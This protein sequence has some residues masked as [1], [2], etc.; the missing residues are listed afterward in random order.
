M[1]TTFIG[2]AMVQVAGTSSS[3]LSS[4]GSHPVRTKGRGAGSA[5]GNYEEAAFSPLFFETGL[6]QHPHRFRIGKQ[7]Q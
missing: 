4:A 2:I 3:R 5:E 6:Q 7:T 1:I